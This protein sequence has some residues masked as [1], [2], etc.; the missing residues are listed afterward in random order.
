MLI[1][2]DID[3][4]LLRSRGVGLRAMQ[5]AL[6]EIHPPRHEHDRHDIEAIDTAGRLDPLIW[7]ELL[8]QRGIEPTD[9]LH[10]RFRET[11]GTLMARMIEDERPVVGLDGAAEAVRWVRDHSEFMA[12]LLTGNYPETGRLKVAG[13]GIDPDDFAFG[14]WGFEASTRR[15]LPPIGIQRGSEH[16]G[17]PIDPADAVIVGDTPADIDCARASGCRVIAV[18]TGRFGMD[19]LAAHQPDELLPD[20]GDLDRFI[21]ALNRTL[22]SNDA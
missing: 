10:D 22:Q 9:A 14:V 8:A 11:Y 5:A 7:R 6:E 17:R 19:E 21:T 18:A 12:A 1:L 2:F 20:L 15:G 16:L 4:T 13:A 3:G